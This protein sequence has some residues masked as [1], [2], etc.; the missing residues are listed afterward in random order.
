MP[1][2]LKVTTSSEA[3][4]PARLEPVNVDHKMLSIERL[5]ASRRLCRRDGHCSDSMLRRLDEAGQLV[6]ASFRS[7]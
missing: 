5:F 3:G 4:V 7:T 2:D 1:V 6:C